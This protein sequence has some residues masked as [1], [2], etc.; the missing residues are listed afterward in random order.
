MR[1]FTDTLKNHYETHP[2]QVSLI[3]QQ[4]GKDDIC[5]HIPGSAARRGGLGCPVPRTEIEPGE[6]IILI[7]QH[8]IELVYA[9][10]GAILHGAIPSILPYLTEKL[11]PER[12]REDLASL[13]GISQPAAIVTFPE[14]EAEVR[15]ALRQGD[16]VRAVILT[17]QDIPI[18]PDFSI[19]GRFGA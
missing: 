14:F 9:Y 10:F 12:Y 2:D 6:V 15:S 4:S 8:S 7:M 11:S 5:H 13:I 17:G 16:S 3:I 1:N 19:T 18:Q